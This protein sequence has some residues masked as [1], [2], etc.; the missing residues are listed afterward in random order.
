MGLSINI[1]ECRRI[2]QSRALYVS[3]KQLYILSELNLY[4]S[5]AESSVHLLRLLTYDHLERMR[6]V[7]KC[8]LW[9][10]EPV[11]YPTTVSNYPE[12]GWKGLTR[13]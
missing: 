9:T 13:Q 1:L 8:E 5:R 11:D 2:F 4:P 3:C 6:R 12:E 10:L 7:L